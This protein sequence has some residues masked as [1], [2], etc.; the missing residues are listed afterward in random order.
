MILPLTAAAH[1]RGTA[2]ADVLSQRG[3]CATCTRIAEMPGSLGRMAEV[4]STNL[5]Y[6]ALPS[7]SRR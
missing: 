2:P 5:A 3:W 7:V 6:S 1:G 4:V